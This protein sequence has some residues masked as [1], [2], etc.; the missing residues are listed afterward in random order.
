MGRIAVSSWGL[1]M[2]ILVATVCG[3]VV[4]LTGKVRKCSKEESRTTPVI[5]LFH[6][7]YKKVE[8]SF[9]YRVLSRV[10][11]FYSTY[12]PSRFYGAL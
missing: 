6:A 7:L 12:T 9:F 5:R 11:D 8:Q 10:L 2:A 4:D 3:E 1:T